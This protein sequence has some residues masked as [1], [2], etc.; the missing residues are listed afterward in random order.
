[1]ERDAHRVAK[2][3]LGAQLQAGRSRHKAAASRPGVIRI[4][5]P[6][7]TFGGPTGGLVLGQAF[8]SS[9]ASDED[10]SR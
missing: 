9:C 3:H 6:E 10:S 2:A 4:E 8:V 5:P 1:M 7:R